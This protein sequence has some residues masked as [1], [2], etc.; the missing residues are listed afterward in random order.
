MFVSRVF[1]GRKFALYQYLSVVMIS[2][3]VSLFMTFKKQK[4][5]EEGSNSWFGIFLVLLNLFLDGFTNS[6]Q[7]NLFVVHKNLTSKQLMFG[8]N[9]SSAVWMILYLIYEQKE[10]NE[11]LGLLLA[12]PAILSDVLLFCIAG[13]VGQIFIFHTLENFGSRTLVTVNVT[14]KVFSILLSVFWFNHGI[15]GYQWMAVAFV[16]AGI[17]LE[18]GMKS[19]AVKVRIEE[20][21]SMEQK[22]KK[23]D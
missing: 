11:G 23:R 5:N 18:S 1:F 21:V 6:K 22:K 7:D 2:V 15:S 13:A 10:L 20:P 19:M 9:V 12:H 14:R 16:F 17:L 4:E 3:G 8:M